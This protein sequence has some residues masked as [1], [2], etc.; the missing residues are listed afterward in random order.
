MS[1][2]SED[3]FPFFQRKELYIWK[4]YLVQQTRINTSAG[5][6]IINNATLHAPNNGK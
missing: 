2:F 1:S 6:K 5:N 4:Q 3:F